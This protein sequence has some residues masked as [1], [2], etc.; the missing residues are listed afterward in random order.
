MLL[1]AILDEDIDEF[2]SEQRFIFKYRKRSNDFAI[3]RPDGKILTLFKPTNGY[4]YNKEQIN[5]L[6]GG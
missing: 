6:K 1:S 2:I 5:K 4:E 3:G